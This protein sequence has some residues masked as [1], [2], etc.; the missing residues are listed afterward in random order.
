MAGAAISVEHVEITITSTNTTGTADITLGQ[1]SANCILIPSFKSATGASTINTRL[2]EVYFSDSNTITAERATGTDIGTITIMVEVIEFDPAQCAVQ[3]GTF[4][5]GSGST[6][7]TATLGSAVSA[8]TAAFAVINY[9]SSYS[10]TNYARNAFCGCTFTNTNTLTFTRDASSGTIIGRYFVVEALGGEFSVQHG[11]IGL[12]NSAEENDDPLPSDVD[13]AKTALFVSM[14]NGHTAD[15]WRTTG[16]RARLEDVA[17]AS[18]VILSRANGGAAS[19]QAVTCDF[20]A[21]TFAQD[22]TVQRGTLTISGTSDTDT[23]ST[24]VDMSI[25]TVHS[26]MTYGLGEGDSTDGTLVGGWFCRM[27]LT[28]TTTVTGTVVDD[29]TPD[30]LYSYEVINWG[31][32]G[33]GGDPVS[34]TIAGQGEA[35][36]GIVR[37]TTGEAEGLAGIARSSSGAAEALAGIARASSGEAEAL[38]RVALASSGAAEALQRVSS[39][40][41]GQAEALAGFVRSASGEAEALAG[42][43]RT[44]AGQAEALGVQVIVFTLAGQLEALAR[45]AATTTGQGEALARVSRALSGEAEALRGVSLGLSGEAEAVGRYVFTLAGQADVLG[46]V[47]YTLAGQGETLKLV[48]SSFSGQ[49]EARLGIAITMKGQVEVWAVA[50]LSD[51]DREM[52]L[53][54]RDLFSISP[55][56][57]PVIY[58]PLGNE[59]AARS[60]RAL[61]VRS[62]LQPLDF[63]EGLGRLGREIDIYLLRS[64]DGGVTAVAPGR[65]TIDIAVNYGETPRRC[66]VTTLRN[67]DVG[68]WHLA[69]TP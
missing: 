24:A 37:T 19:A 68:K 66:R 36:T 18:S 16:V 67:A 53:M 3:Q 8:T 2:P 50:V 25:S 56:T 57:E 6:S 9:R 35:L 23:L 22:E 44:A 15:D 49:L 38:G 54:T 52:I 21:V 64:D 61:I 13:L 33:G 12:S 32:G 40:L 58:Y 1:D 10:S 28:D 7:N 14:Q 63:T 31:F 27:E 29:I 43:T 17:G 11:T 34:F 46:R 26:P 41:A 5:V 51:H 65:D 47:L 20:Q 55:T 39:S 45:I 60:I 48:G 42:I 30:G 62:A 69:V 59:A 4:S